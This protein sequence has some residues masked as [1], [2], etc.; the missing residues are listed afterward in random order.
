[1]RPVLNDEG[2][3]VKTLSVGGR[4]EARVLVD[5]KQPFGV[6]YGVP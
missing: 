2:L 3:I 5:L 6:V 4:L 1:M